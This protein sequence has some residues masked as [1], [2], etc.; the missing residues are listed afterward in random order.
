MVLTMVRAATDAQ[1][2][3]RLQTPVTPLCALD[4]LAGAEPASSILLL[5]QSMGGG[6]AAEL[7]ATHFP[8]LACVNMRSFSSLAHVSAS[9]IGLASSTA[10]RLEPMPSAMMDFHNALDD[11][12]IS[13]HRT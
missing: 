1:Q 10:G 4:P 2:L 8:H 5:G 12:P 13:T 7:A 6:V 11:F 9:T 3:T